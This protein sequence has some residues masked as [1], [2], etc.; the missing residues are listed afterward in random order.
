PT[1][2]DEVTREKSGTCKTANLIEKLRTGFVDVLLSLL[3]G[4][5]GLGLRIRLRIE[6]LDGLTKT[7]LSGVRAGRRSAHCGFRGHIAHQLSKPAREISVF[8]YM[9]RCNELTEVLECLR[10]CLEV[11][12]IRGTCQ[13]L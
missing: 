9:S 2:F 10:I 7:H 13:G 3:G 12:E 6:R 8:T 4:L 5:F 11:S 1:P